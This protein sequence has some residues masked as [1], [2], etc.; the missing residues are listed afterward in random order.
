MEDSMEKKRAA[1]LAR[2]EGRGKKAAETKQASKATREKEERT[3]EELIEDSRVEIENGIVNEMTEKRLVEAISLG[4]SAYLEVK[5]REVLA[6]VRKSILEKETQTMAAFTFYTGIKNPPPRGQAAPP[7]MSDDSSDDVEEE[8][9]E[10]GDQEMEEQR[11]ER[12]EADIQCI[13]HHRH[14]ETIEGEDGSSVRLAHLDNCSIS[15]NFCPSTV[16]LE[17]LTDTT[18]IMLPVQTS[19]LIYGSKRLRLFGEAQQIRVHDVEESELHVGVRGVGGLILESCKGVLVGKC[20]KLSVVLLYIR[21]NSYYLL[22]CSL[23]SSGDP[24]P[25]H[26]GDEWRRAKDFDWLAEGQSP[27]WREASEEEW[28][29]ADVVTR[30]VEKWKKS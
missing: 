12:R 25:I 23:R 7:P 9:E 1:M 21:G 30:S 15:L 2:L 13:A 6:D 29:V 24:V 10:E 27:N 26:E 28:K 4:P 5:L 3:L 18:V 22:N 17:A 14:E 8:E 19:I 16:H 11:E 20:M